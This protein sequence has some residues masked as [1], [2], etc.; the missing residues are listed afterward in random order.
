MVSSSRDQPAWYDA[1]PRGQ[2]AIGH[3]P[4]AVRR[5]AAMVHA[6]AMDTRT[7]TSV[8]TGANRGLGLEFTRQLLAAGD[9]VVAA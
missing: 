8:V 7:R 4:P 5:A 2:R 6:R 9:H 3:G 1:A